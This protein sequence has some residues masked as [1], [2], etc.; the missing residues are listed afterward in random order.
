MSLR[1]KSLCAALC[2]SI[3]LWALTIQGALFLTF[4]PQTDIEVQ[5]AASVA[6]ISIYFRPAS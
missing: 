6:E 5:V 2:L 4:E 1:I 3:A